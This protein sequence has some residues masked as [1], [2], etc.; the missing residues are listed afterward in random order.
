MVDH[1][2]EN[3][4]KGWKSFKSENKNAGG[5]AKSYRMDGHEEMAGNSTI[6]RGNVLKTR[7]T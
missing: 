4:P 1:G 7:I 3:L 5:E 6:S 2:G